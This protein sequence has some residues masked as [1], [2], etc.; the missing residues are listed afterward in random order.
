M[1][2]PRPVFLSSLF[3]AFKRIGRPFTVTEQNGEL[4]KSL[5]VKLTAATVGVVSKFVMERALGVLW[6]VS[7]TCF[8]S[9]KSLAAD[10]LR[11]TAIPALV[12]RCSFPTKPSG[13]K[14]KKH[15]R[16][17]IFRDFD[18]LQAMSNELSDLQVNYPSQMY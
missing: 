13:P 5:Q 17:C 18:T 11:H 1:T 3:S 4:R 2:T 7:T 16:I 10:R 15:T 6:R 12:I 8:R 9:A 14:E